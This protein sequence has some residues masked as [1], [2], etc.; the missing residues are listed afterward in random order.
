[1]IRIERLT[2]SY[3]ALQALVDVDLEIA[4]GECLGLVGSNGSGRTTLLRVAATLVPPTSGSVDIDGLDVVRHVYRLRPR[5]AYVG[6]EAVDAERMRVAEYVRLVLEA[7]G[8]P[9][10][11]EIVDAAVARAGL[12]AQ[13]SCVS[14]SAGLRQRLL[15]GAVLAAEPDVLLLDDPFRALDASSRSRVIEWIG[16]ARGRGAAIMLA[17]Q[18]DE[19]IAAACT[20]VARFDRGRLAGVSAVPKS[21]A[22]SRPAA[23]LR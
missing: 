10:T 9:A 3:G 13:S 7:R 16:D 14:L 22:A 4:R 17:T 15:L 23:A 18:S 19:D 11:R 6:V 5:I 21:T 1:M 20:R 2:K 8:R 12:D